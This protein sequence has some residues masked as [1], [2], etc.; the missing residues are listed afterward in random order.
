MADQHDTL[1]R[2]VE[3]ELRR[4]RLEQFWQR[5]GIFVIAAAVLIVVGV[6]GYKWWEARSIAAAEEAGLR[7]EAAVLLASSGK[8][9]EAKAALAKIAAEGPEGYA[10]L[11]RLK[12]AGEAAK[13]GKREE[14]TTAYEALAEDGS[15]DPLLRDYARLQ[16]AA[17]R[18]DTADWTEMKNRLNPLI[19]DENAWRYSAR[20]LLGL[21][22]YRAGRFDEARG[23]LS[24]LA[25]DPKAPP[26]M[27]E[28]ANNIMSL[29][30][31]GELARN[32]PSGG[33]RSAGSSDSLN[34]TEQPMT[35][36]QTKGAPAKGDGSK[37]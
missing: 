19:G 17:L 13:A 22:A 11:A 25:T 31:A 28:R 6:A 5:Y 8:A 10:Q 12:L 30:V 27:R 4:E 23:A 32:A 24:A 2:Q 3:E 18:L 26:A 34:K 20:E 37:K 29:V 21:A 33:G 15:A 35:P 14:A 7:Y 16:A 9:D 36:H 1:L